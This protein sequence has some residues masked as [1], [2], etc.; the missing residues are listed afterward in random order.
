VG[1]GVLCFIVSGPS[2]SGKTSV[3]D[4]LMRA[5]PDLMFSVSY[6]TRAPR[7]GEQD[8][9]E[10]YFVR[11]VD[12]EAM[13]ARNELLEYA[14]VFG[15]YYGTHRSVLDRAAQAGKDLLLDI[16]VQGAAQVKQKVPDAISVF[17]LPPS[18]E[19]LEQ[20]LRYR[21]LDPE[22]VIE[23]RLRQAA[24]EIS[25][26]GSY[27]FVLVNDNLEQASARLNA[28]VLAERWKRRNGNG[29]AADPE[30]RRWMELAESR[31]T[32]R[33]RAEI[34]PILKTFDLTDQGASKL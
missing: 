33:V 21:R 6:T 34:E 7:A 25:G 32:A 26:Y 19:V 28:I 24:S 14:R 22:H 2:G 1:R 23:R 11:P 5:V 12:F 16:D 9:R 27:D 20:R 18:R 30:V 4:H 15:Q 17:I 29:A 8:G 10:Y 31:R 3:V 13:I